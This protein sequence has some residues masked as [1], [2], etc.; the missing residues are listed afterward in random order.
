MQD[1]Q[2]QNVNEKHA[3]MKVR[4]QELESLLPS[5]KKNKKKQKGDTSIEEDVDVN[6]VMK[7]VKHIKDSLSSLEIDWEFDQRK[8]NELYLKKLELAAEEKRKIQEEEIKARKESEQDKPKDNR[9]VLDDDVDDD[10][11]GLF[12]GLMGEEEE[13]AYGTEGANQLNTEAR[14]TII[15][16]SV[17]QSWKGQYPKDVLADYCKRNSLGKQTYKTTEHGFDT[18]RSAL[19]IAQDKHPNE[20][21]CFELPEGLATKSRNNAENLIAV[22]K[23]YT[24]TFNSL[25][26]RIS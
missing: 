10:E 18:W 11:G 25:I 1:E 2:D 24:N 4:L 26:E 21:L 23:L 14:W 12:G 7:E 13:A 8:A 6:A 15:E 17:P 22:D 19:K 16:L 3:M 20:P 9:D 5:K